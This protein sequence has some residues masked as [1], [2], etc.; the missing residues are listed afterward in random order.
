MKYITIFGGSSPKPDSQAYQNAYQ[1]GMLLAKA[2]YS[3]VTGGYMGTMEAASKGAYEHGGH[4]IGVTCDE[5]E[6]WRNSKHNAWVKEEIREKTLVKRI[7][8]M[9]NLCDAAFALPGGPGTLAEITLMWNL[10]QI[11][12]IPPKPI[13]LVGDGWTTIMQHFFENQK[14]YFSANGKSLLQF[15]D[16]IE[17]GLAILPLPSSGN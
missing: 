5:I 10:K 12:A 3:V 17:K 15:V 7:S 8:T 13:I 1:L 16:T 4:V 14:D 9:I 11:Q 6:Q 2:G